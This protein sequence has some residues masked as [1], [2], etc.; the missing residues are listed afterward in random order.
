MKNKGLTIIL[1]ITILTLIGALVFTTIKVKELQSKVNEYENGTTVENVEE[2]TTATETKVEEKENVQTKALTI[3]ELLDTN[4]AKCINLNEKEHY[5]TR[6]M[7]SAPYFDVYG[8]ARQLQF[9]VDA[10]KYNNTF[11]QNI[12]GGTY[13]VDLSKDVAQVYYCQFGNGMGDETVAILYIDGTVDYILA[14]DIFKGQ[15]TVKHVDN[16]DNVVYLKGVNAGYEQGG[17]GVATIA[18]K[19]DGTIVM[20]KSLDGIMSVQ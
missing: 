19:L 6:V 12:A 7:T 3:S 16:L 17:G 5:N 11:N 13:T 15:T 8:N 18:V 9:S 10:E 4:E 2:K 20:L 1:I 14:N